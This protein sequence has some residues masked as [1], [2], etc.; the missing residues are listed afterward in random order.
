[1]LEQ[2]S[3]E[4]KA[5]LYDRAK[6]PLFG[7]FVL[8]WLGWN[9]N[10]VLVL[11]SELKYAEKI[12]A[13]KAIY[14]DGLSWWG[15]AALLP[16]LSSVAFIL[17]YPYP[18]RWMFQYWYSQHKKMK[19]VQQRIEDETPMTQEEAIA[20]RRTALEEQLA[21]QKQLGELSA[22]NRELSQQVK[23]LFETLANVEGERD[24][25]K[26]QLS[27]VKDDL[28]AA[29]IHLAEQRVSSMTGASDDGSGLR[30]FVA[31]KPLVEATAEDFMAAVGQQPTR[32]NV[33]TFKHM[34][35]LL[36]ADDVLKLKAAVP[37]ADDQKVM[38]TLIALVHCGGSATSQSIAKITNE[39]KVAVEYGLGKLSDAG[40]A[41][42]YSGTHFLSDRG[43]ELAI[44]AHITD[45]LTS[46]Q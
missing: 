31:N 27:Q 12:S 1:M 40:I 30:S 37:A 8:A 28:A 42:T 17:I 18:A 4:V 14:G 41:K 33:Y 21:T 19:E 39:N 6:S 3:K 46:L 32:P 25:L 24:D 2:L 5:Q 34:C 15:H 23:N 9:F 7:G 11:F 16:L 43:R 45:A 26:Q 10:A 35:S 13:W 29:N 38:G 20:L 22:K 36:S 44:E